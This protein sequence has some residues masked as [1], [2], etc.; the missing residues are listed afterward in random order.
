MSG[1]R[2]EDEFDVCAAASWIRANIGAPQLSTLLNDLPTVTQFSGGASNLTYL[3]T[4]PSGARMILRRP[5]TGRKSVGAHNMSR[6]FRLQKRLHP[7]FSLIAEPYALCED[8]GVIGNPFYVMEYVSGPIAR[9][10]LP[11]RLTEDPRAV[12]ILCRRVVDILID[13]H[14]VPVEDAGLSDV[15]RGGG[16]VARQ[17]EGWAARYAEART[18]NV[19]SFATVVEW[20]RAHRPEDLPSVIVHNDFRFDNI[21]LQPEDPTVPKA[22]LDWEMATVGDPLM[23]LGG[24]LAYW[25]Q[26]DDGWLFRRFRRQPTHVPGMMTRREVIAYY[27]SRTGLPVTEEQWSF[28][29]VFGLFRLAAI[30]QQ[31]YY[32]YYH[33]QT[34]NSSFRFFGIA[35]V[36][37]E[38][39]CRRIIRRIERQ[40]RR[41][42]AD[43]PIVSGRPR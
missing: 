26:A 1:V 18:R 38:L 22:L 21:V 17:V 43:S 37:L 9:R 27:S 34:T 35:V 30:C 24:A 41:G 23:D 10:E 2:S 32:R 19:G 40:R 25:V 6:E 36:A 15:D 12:S 42:T 29:E 20:L 8:S 11:Q 7:H 13:L 3:L 5:P 16:Y 31:I 14:A 33:R 28:Y 39:R 4:Y